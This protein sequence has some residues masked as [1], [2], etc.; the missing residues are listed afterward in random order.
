MEIP[1]L[2]GKLQLQL[3][4]YATVTATRDP[5]LVCDLH[6]SSQQRQILNPQSE[7]RDGT[8]NLKVPGQIRFHCTTT[9]TPGMVFLIPPRNLQGKPGCPVLQMEESRLRMNK[10]LLVNGLRLGPTT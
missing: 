8:H 9:G 2:G 3:P 1:R 5:S 4:A 10:Y 6:H 7:A